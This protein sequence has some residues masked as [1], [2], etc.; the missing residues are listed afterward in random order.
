MSV[1]DSKCAPTAPRTPAP[2]DNLAWSLLPADW[3][4][5]CRDAGQPSF[6][7]KQIW[8]WLYR[9]RVSTWDAMTNL[10]ASWRR[11][12]AERHAIDPWREFNSRQAGDG[13]AK[14]LLFARD[15]QPIESVLIPS[16]DRL[17]LCVSTQAGC[18]FGCIFCATGR[19]GLA[20]DLATG[21]IVG[22]YM[23]AARSTP[24]RITHIVVM[25]MGEPFANYD[26][27]LRA[28]RILNDYDGI[29]IGARRITLS[30]CGVVPGIRRLAEENLQVELSVSL[31]APT[32]E[33]RSRLMPVNRKWPLNE[34]MP[35]C[36]DYTQRTGRII[37][38]EYIL[39]AG[40]NDSPAH[41][42]ALLALVRPVGGRVNLIPLN[43]V[44]GHEGRPP[45]PAACEDFAR[46]LSHG[47]LNVTLRHSR[48]GDIDAA[49]G[50][51]RLRIQERDNQ[52]TT[53]T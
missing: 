41:A 36:G 3:T 40:L 18:A 30:T 31:H 35:A 53:L 11:E 13:V 25:G 1:A 15:G 8:Q 46:R 4:A 23:A 47:G 32:D 48:G 5:I 52:L 27:T 2:L 37:T 19:G 44:E 24:R 33:L 17:T 22:Q 42:D 43:P 28:V 38:F 9:E 26:A 45:A 6:R 14:L 7:A 49:C 16:A 21:E 12:L 29:G 34:L 20:R 50:Q 39:V 10:P 51:L